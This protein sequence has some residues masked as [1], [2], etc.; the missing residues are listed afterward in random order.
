M[1]D[2]LIEQAQ[3]LRDLIHQSDRVPVPPDQIL[4]QCVVP[5][6]DAIEIARVDGEV[7]GFMLSSVYVDEA[8][9][10]VFVVSDSGFAP[11]VLPDKD[12]DTRFTRNVYERSR[13]LLSSDR[14]KIDIDK[15]VDMI[16]KAGGSEVWGRRAAQLANVHL[17]SVNDV[18]ES[19]M[20]QVFATDMDSSDMA[21]VTFI[22]LVAVLISDIM[23][24]C[25]T[26]V[27][28][29][30]NRRRSI[31]CT[32]LL[33]KSTSDGSA[34]GSSKKQ[35]QDSGNGNILPSMSENEAMAMASLKGAIRDVH[36]PWFRV[37][38]AA[39][40]PWDRDMAYYLQTSPFYFKGVMVKG[41][42]NIP[43]FCKVWRECDDH[44]D[45]EDVKDKIDLLKVANASG[46]PSPVVVEELTALNVEY[47][48]KD[49]KRSV[50][51]HILVTS[52]ER[53]DPVVPD[54]LLQFALSLVQAV[55]KLHACGILHGDIKP[56]NVLWDMTQGV[57]R[58][59]DFGHAQYESKARA[60]HATK[61]YQAPEISQGEPHT[62]KSDA[63]GVD[64]AIEREIES[65][66]REGKMY[67][68]VLNELVRFLLARD[69]SVRI[70]LD[71]AE[72]RLE[73]S[74]RELSTTGNFVETSRQ[75]KASE[76]RYIGQQGGSVGITQ[77]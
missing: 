68:P 16:K 48:R 71:D 19:E 35:K 36:F 76:R 42:K 72:R 70:S 46:I 40:S 10:K 37:K 3:A 20:E 65:A 28:S 15:L 52:F 43:V 11:I 53:D 5:K 25:K 14:T 55:R 57:A 12:S 56:G 60:Y 29:T 22:S 51:F 4:S 9:E 74:L 47:V 1:A 24:H 41:S 66:R 39:L 59:I 38:N 21:K 44:V 34:R 58:L 62:K 61:K 2:P 17:P 64:K 73:R 23:F 33:S 49:S 63:F 18:T 30:I 31:G 75:E 26:S 13:N 69:A 50:K 32:N 27:T 54:D 45:R 8:N 77:G 67:F 6:S 7:E